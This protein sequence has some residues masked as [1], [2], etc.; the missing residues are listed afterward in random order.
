M[1]IFTVNKRNPLYEKLIK[2]VKKRSLLWNTSDALHRNT[3]E[4]AKAWKE[5]ANKINISEDAAKRKWQMLRVVFLRYI[6]KNKPR[7]LADYTGKWKYF[8]SMWFLRNGLKNKLWPTDDVPNE[9]AEAVV[10]VTMESD[11][12]TSSMEDE[13]DYQFSTSDDE[14]LQN[15][16]KRTI[17]DTTGAKETNGNQIKLSSINCV[18]NNDQPMVI[19]IEN[20]GAIAGEILTNDEVN[21][22]TQTPEFIVLDT[23]VTTTMPIQIRNTETNREAPR[24][25]KPIDSD[26]LFLKSLAP[27][28]RK[29]TPARN[30]AIRGKFQEILMYELAR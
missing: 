26:E 9:K 18:S 13:E 22:N 4:K 17:P 27:F 28:L 7:T 20:D 21:V 5:I 19:T 24:P 10:P 6:K 23:D 1:N 29:L 11:V 16:V 3:K 14:V 2:E 15:I 30:L 25:E 12:S 8:R